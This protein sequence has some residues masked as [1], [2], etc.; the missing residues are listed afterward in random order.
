[1]LK[2]NSRSTGLGDNST[3]SK[4]FLQSTP[5]FISQLFSNIQKSAKE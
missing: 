4:Q 2:D 1:M 5:A 3:Q